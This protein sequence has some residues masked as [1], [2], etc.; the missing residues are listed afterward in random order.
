MTVH[1]C[2]VSL[3]AE[4]LPELKLMGRKYKKKKKNAA[5]AIPSYFVQKKMLR[6]YRLFRLIPL[7]V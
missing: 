2:T 7:S 5:H 1:G 6:Q 4:V 3:K